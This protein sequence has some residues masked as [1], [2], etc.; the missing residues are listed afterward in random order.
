MAAAFPASSHTRSLLIIVLVA[1][2]ASFLLL[3]LF[4]SQPPSERGSTPRFDTSSSVPAAT[5]QL[6]PSQP[7]FSS[8]QL[9]GSLVPQ[10][11]PVDVAVPSE[12]L[13]A[14]VKELLA[15]WDPTRAISPST[16]TDRKGRNAKNGR[17]KRG[18]S[19]KGNAP[20]NAAEEETASPLGESAKE[21]LPPAPPVPRAP[22]LVDCAERA[23]LH[24]EEWW[25]ARPADGSLPPWA[26]AWQARDHASRD[27]RAY[28]MLPRRER[29]VDREGEEEGEKEEGEGEEEDEGVRG[30]EVREKADHGGGAGAH[31]ATAAASSVGA[32]AAA[33]AAAETA[34]P[35]S[36]QFSLST[37]A[38]VIAEGP[39]PPWVEGGE[40][41]NLPLTR[42]VQ[43]HLWR[44]QFPANCSLPHV[45]CAPP[46]PVPFSAHPPFR[47]SSL[48]PILPSA[49]PLPPITSPIPIPHAAGCALLSQRHALSPP[50][51]PLPLAFMYAAFERR[52][53]DGFEK[54]L[55]YMAAALGQAVQQ[56][57]VLVA[58]T[59]DRAQHA[60]LVLVVAALGQAVQQGRVLVARTYDRAHHT[61]CD[62][63]ANAHWHCYFLPETSDECRRR[64]KV[65]SELPSSYVGPDP[66]SRGVESQR[67]LCRSEFLRRHENPLPPYN[68]SPHKR[69]K[70]LLEL[71]FE[72]IRKS[73]SSSLQPSPHRRVKELSELPSS[74]TGADPLIVTGRRVTEAPLEEWGEGEG[75]KGDADVAAAE[76][77][78]N[79]VPSVDSSANEGVEEAKPGRTGSAAEYFR[80]EVPRVWGK[81]WLDMVGR[82]GEPW[83]VG[84]VGAGEEAMGGI[85]G[86]RGVEED[87]SGGG[88]GRDDG[89]NGSRSDPKQ[90]NRLKHLWWRAQAL[91]FLL[92]APSPYL[93]HVSNV[94]RHAEFGPVAARMAALGEAAVAHADV[95]GEVGRD[96]DG[97]DC[98]WEECECVATLLS[99]VAHFSL[100]FPSLFSLSLFPLSFPSLFSLSLFS[101]SFLSLFGSQITSIPLLHL[102]HLSHLSRLCRIMESDLWRRHRAVWVPRPL[103]GV[104]VGRAGQVRV[105]TAVQRT[106]GALLAVRQHLP[107]AR[108]V[109]LTADEQEAGVQRSMGALLA[110]RQQLPAAR[111]VWLTADEQEPLDQL[112]ATPGWTWFDS[113][114][115]RLSSSSS[116][117]ASANQQ[118]VLQKVVGAAFTNLLVAQQADVFIG[119]T[120]SPRSYLIYALRSTSGKLQSSFLDTGV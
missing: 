4:S 80:A 70:E 18:K 76:N 45:R 60:G 46:P 30:R 92:R 21:P 48:P 100:S 111:F 35:S 49:H 107:A 82:V 7:L 19:A 5:L 41:A 79:Q 66:K 116:T 8:Q 23:R 112:A 65:L 108:F 58:R 51:A 110:V 93:C 25:A 86:G 95:A 6:N 12:R 67:R 90:L 78:A 27:P 3:P 72:S 64:V 77:P 44:R 20:A 81:P 11:A 120:K 32:A 56:G 40:G 36:Q 103:V 105:Q 54:Q 29:A 2:C 74:Y 68:P 104:H 26:V 17:K 47:P 87:G 14:R 39:F 117:G 85:G 59:Y 9:I 33:A 102:S 52:R 73:S 10:I 50:L 37:D 75:D 34:E 38:D 1:L 42:L 97:R 61:G 31:V 109:W 24:R 22:H 89:V 28:E 88:R 99:L 57:R 94:I 91:R 69:V 113:H 119:S 84:G 115:P 63:E 106:M 55:A 71:P 16:E 53:R 15:A 98:T 13:E 114:T 118:Q 96:C 62:G 83:G 43:T 101:H